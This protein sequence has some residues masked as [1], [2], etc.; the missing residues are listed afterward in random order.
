M[1][2]RFALIP[3]S[4]AAVI[5]FVG[6][7]SQRHSERADE[8]VEVPKDYGSAAVDGIETDAWCSDF[9]QQGLDRLVERAWADNLQLKAAWARLEQ[10]RATAE[11]AEAP[12]WPS[13]GAEAGVSYSKRYLGD[14]SEAA[15]GFL[16]DSQTETNWSLSAAAAYEVDVWGKYRHRAHA[17][18]LEA[19]AVEA[20]TRSLAITLTSQVAEA[21][22]DVIAQRERLELLE[23][24]L[25]LSKDLLELTQ[26][27]FERGLADALDITQQRQNL[28]S[29]TAQVSA[30]RGQLQTSRHRLAVLVGRPPSE[31]IAIDAETLPELGPIPAPGVPA[32]LL[33]RRPDVRAAFLQLQ[34]ADE[35]TAAAVAD[36]LPSLRL[37]ANIAIQAQ[38]LSN[39]LEQLFWSVAAGVSQPIF[40]G[41]RLRAEVRRSEAA[42]EEQ[43]YDYAQTLLTA[44]REVRDALVL[45]QN[46]VERIASLRRELD[47]AQSALDLAQSRYRR[48]SFDYLRVLTAL[49]SLQAVEQT[50]LEARRQHISYRISLCR[51]LGG[52]WVEQIEAPNSQPS[53]DQPSND[54]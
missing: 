4:T 24:Q 33:E 38:E 12:L 32:D 3:L 25:D 8:V 36:Q 15:Q 22:F 50:L 21:W 6:C 11:I 14:I 9:G 7:T 16:P 29:L 47:T 35:R 45:E 26:R 5:A 17:A 46:Q 20:S 43:L 49:Q 27:R 53:N 2:A 37:S 39:L 19:E 13:V 40:E 48:G 1:P 18:D 41:G 23:A 51:A 28:E 34:A 44:L 30:V 52:S 54:E 31:P 42:A 10:A